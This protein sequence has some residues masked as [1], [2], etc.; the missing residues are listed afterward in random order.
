MKINLII[1][2]VCLV[3]FL[4]RAQEEKEKGGFKWPNGL[5]FGAQWSTLREVGGGTEDPISGFYAGYLRRV[6]LIPFFR[7]ETGMEYMQ[8]GGHLV[9]NTKLKLHYLVLPLQVVAKLGPLFI[10]GGA[11]ANFLLH[12]DLFVDGNKQGL[13]SDN[14][15]SFFDVTVDGGAG[16]SILFLAIELRYYYGLMEVKNQYHNQQLQLG[17]KIHF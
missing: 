3:A 6:N 1:I 4:A 10:T 15:A 16:L 17:L 5:R 14:K 12:Q 13:N 9:N 11:N 8:G 2:A 7:L